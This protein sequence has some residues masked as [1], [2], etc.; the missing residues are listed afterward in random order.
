[1]SSFL[2]IKLALR[3][4]PQLMSAQRR[5][6]M[7]AFCQIAASVLLLGCG[8]SG[9]APTKPGSGGQVVGMTIDTPDS[10]APITSQ[11]LDAAVALAQGAGVRGVIATYTWSEL[12]PSPG[13][14][15]VSALQSGLSY[16]QQKGLQ[17]F[18]GI[19]VINTVKREV[20]SDLAQVAFDDPQFISRF[21]ALLDAV[22]GA[23]SGGERYISIGNEVDVYLGSQPDQWG[24]YT[25]F[26]SDA[27]SYVHAKS[28]Q[29][30]VGVTTTFSG[31]SAGNPAAVQALNAASD[32]VILTYYPL[33]GDSQVI[34]ATAPATDLPMMISL[35]GNKPVVLQ[36]AG[37]PSGTLNGSSD[38]DQQQFVAS[39]FQSWRAAGSQMPFL[40]YFLLYDLDATTCNALGVYYGSSDPAFLSFLCSLGLRTSDGTAKPAWNEFVQDAQ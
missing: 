32:V 27:V 21:H 34:A 29:L 19:Q 11:S 24:A 23:L 28:P 2:R 17:I 8:G 30:S 16:Y 10:S 20:P 39:L 12:E 40:S 1:M 38:T 9:S 13:Q 25:T 26:Y 22:R 14:I 7:S 5:C 15:D 33:Q 6:T 4:Y 31:Y 3:P 18:L 37:F 35:A 36:E